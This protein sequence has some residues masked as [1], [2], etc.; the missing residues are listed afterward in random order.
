[1]QRPRKRPIYYNACRLYDQTVIAAFPDRKP[2][3]KKL[4]FYHAKIGEDG[5]F[6]WDIRSGS[7]LRDCNY[8]GRIRFQDIIA[9]SLNARRAVRDIAL[10][11]IQALSQEVAELR[12]QLTRIEGLFKEQGKASS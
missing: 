1:M 11:A 6:G 10:P 3:P 2:L 8:E 5:V 12:A 9:N 4:K 7:E